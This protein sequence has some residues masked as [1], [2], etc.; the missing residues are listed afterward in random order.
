MFVFRIVDPS[1]ERKTVRSTLLRKTGLIAIGALVSAVL[2]VPPANATPGLFGSHD[3]TYDGVYRQ[4][5]LIVALRAHGQSIPA[6][7]R[8]WLAGQQCAD[9]GFESF[10]ADTGKPCVAPDAANFVGEDTNSTAAAALAFAATGDKARAAKAI[11]YLRAAQSSDGGFP[12]YL[13]GTSDV[14]ST[15]LAMLAFRANR[16]A[17]AAVVKQ[18]KSA[19]AYLSGNILGCSSSTP[20]AFSFWGEPSEK[21]TVQALVALRS[22]LPW[23]RAAVINDFWP[24]CPA[25]STPSS[26]WSAAAFHTVS[27]L[28]ANTFAIPIPAAWGGGVDI[29]DTAWA[30]LGLIGTGR[31]PAI[32]AST[33]NALRIAAKDY[34]VDKQGQPLVG[35]VALLLLVTAANGDSPRNFGEIGRAHV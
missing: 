20:G 9:G 26:L 15:A 22:T 32:A 4:S 2:T 29:S 21:A 27:T 24:A 12:Y 11:A 6:A 7:A 19:Y 16:V 18:G 1:L 3:A 14:N 35:R 23:K 25:P 31:E 30:A 5:L 28:T 34:V 13:G 33:I 8:T 17:P 10:R